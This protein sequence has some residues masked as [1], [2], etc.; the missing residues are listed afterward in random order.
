MYSR[1]IR[2]RMQLIRQ[3]RVVTMHKYVVGGDGTEPL[4]FCIIDSP[5]IT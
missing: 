2:D 5:T 4:E 3:C 1:E